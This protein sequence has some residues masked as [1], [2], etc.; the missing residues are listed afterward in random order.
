MAVMAAVA[1]CL[2]TAIADGD[3]LSAICDSGGSN[4]T[5]VVRLAEIDAPEKGQP[6]GAR[7][8][9]HLGAMCF[10]R[11]A[12][13]RPVAK[14]RYDRTVAKVEC[15]GQDVGLAMLDAGLAWRFVRYSRDPAALVAESR[16]REARQGLWRDDA[17]VAP[18][19]WRAAHR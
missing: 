14:D 18:W 5:F 9:E 1:V 8:R 12:T 19:D 2:V 4:T 3:T 17:A 16:A 15:Q 6:F 7:A 10:G 13:I 11:E